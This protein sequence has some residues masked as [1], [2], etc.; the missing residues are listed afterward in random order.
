M[1]F[2]DSATNGASITELYREA[3]KSN[4]VSHCSDP[5][6]LAARLQELPV[7]FTAF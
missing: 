7:A 1:Y 4:E 3:V 6:R 2:N 5:D